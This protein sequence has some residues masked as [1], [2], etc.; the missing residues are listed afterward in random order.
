MRPEEPS[1]FRQPRTEFMNGRPPQRL[2]TAVHK[3]YRC[4]AFYAGSY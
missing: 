3:P 2:V 1:E 4:R